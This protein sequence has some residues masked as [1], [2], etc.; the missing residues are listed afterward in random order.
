MEDGQI[1]GTSFL[2]FVQTENFCRPVSIRHP[3]DQGSSSDDSRQ[4]VLISINIFSSLE[5]LVKKKEVPANTTR[6]SDVGFRVTLCLLILRLEILRSDRGS[7]LRPGRRKKA[8]FIRD[9]ADLVRKVTLFLG[10]PSVLLYAKAQNSRQNHE[11]YAL[12]T[13]DAEKKTE[14]VSRFNPSGMQNDRCE[15]WMQV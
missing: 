5:P 9:A 8:Q 4:E 13:L 7:N 15:R 1:L 10:G 6:V 14:M 2:E 3:T 11:A 12:G